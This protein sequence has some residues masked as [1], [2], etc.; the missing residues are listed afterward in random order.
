MQEKYDI[1]GF[2]ASLEAGYTFKVKQG[3]EYGYFLQPKAQL[4]WMDVDADD[5]VESNGTRVQG[6]SGNLQTRLG[7]KAFM[8]ND[9]PNADKAWQPFVE[10]NWIHNSDPYNISMNE[11]KFEQAGADNIG[12]V[13]LG[14][15]R[16]ST[17]N[18]SLWLNGAY[19]FGS[20]SYQNYG[21]KAGVKY[22][23]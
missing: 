9:N 17:K 15:E 5:H 2:T 7:L 4:T 19:Q 14:F 20:N 16:R 3:K 1:S 11:S 12:E 22:A 21:V 10:V 8:S 18:A 6:G 23:F 13:K